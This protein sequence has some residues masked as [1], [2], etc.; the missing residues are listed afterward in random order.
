MKNSLA[1]SAL[2]VLFA[3]QSAFAHDM[4]VPT[5]FSMTMQRGGQRNIR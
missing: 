2:L 5:E 3:H 1:L 4:N